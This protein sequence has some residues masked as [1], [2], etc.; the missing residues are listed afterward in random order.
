[1][2]Y[3]AM[4]N[5]HIVYCI[6]MSMNVPS[7]RQ[8]LSLF[9]SKMSH[10]IYFKCWVP[11]WS[12]CMAH[13]SYTIYNSSTLLQIMCIWAEGLNMVGLW[14]QSASSLIMYPF[15]HERVQGLRGMP[16]VSLFTRAHSYILL[17]AAG[18]KQSYHGW[19]QATSTNF[20]QQDKL[21]KYL[22]IQLHYFH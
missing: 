9:S 14:K 19:R 11:P 6:N 10:K 12:Y 17:C 3:F 21:D 15:L 20:S 1:M 4:V 16:L 13:Y 18:G 8:C 7:R 2:L 22:D 5:S